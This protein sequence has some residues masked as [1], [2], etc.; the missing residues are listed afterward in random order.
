MRWIDWFG[1]DWERPTPPLGRADWVLAAGVTLALM[2]CQVLARSF[3]DFSGF[4][5]HSWRE[6]AVIACLFP[7]LL[8]RRRYPLSCAV[9]AFAH[10]FW[11][12]SW[13]PQVNLLSYQVTVFALLASGVAWARDRRTTG[14]VMWGLVVAMGLWVGFDLAIGRGLEQLHEHLGEHWGQGPINPTIA[15]VAFSVLVNGASM[16]GAIAIGQANWN[17]ARTQQVLSRQAETIREQADGLRDQAVVEERLRIA[18]ELHD[19][20]A[21]HVAVMG[22]QAAGARRVLERDPATAAEA[23]QNVEESSRQAVTQM[24]SLLGALR[25]AEQDQ[26]TG[27]EPQPSLAELPALVD[28][29]RASG[30]AV[31]LTVVEDRPGAATSLPLPVQLSLY[32]TVQ[33]ALANVRRHSTARNAS[34]TVRVQAPPTGV[35]WAE[36]EVVDDGR[37]LGGTSGSGLGLLGMRERVTSH[38]GSSEI[39]PRVTGG[40]RV[41][42]RL[43]LGTTTTLE[44]AR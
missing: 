16:L 35:G 3:N 22:I 34:V 40:Y 41:R 26:G 1:D 7:L 14:L 44:G 19:V 6:Y 43:P 37:P 25:G 8:L 24:R 32:R 10:F 5:G 42:V 4:P 12:L 18:R 28:D 13:F 9:L 39:G 2:L 17:Q 29:V 11:A 20:V 30:L 15:W 38:G 36:A 27:R 33:E 23:L 31:D 21:H